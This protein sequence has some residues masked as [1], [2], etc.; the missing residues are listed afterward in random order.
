MHG[1]FHTADSVLFAGA[2]TDCCSVFYKNNGVGRDSSFNRPSKKQIFHFF[3]A[4]RSGRIGF[5][6]FIHGGCGNEILSGA[7]TVDKRL[8]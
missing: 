2:D 7:D 3:G 8:L 1:K 5:A 4:C 6:F